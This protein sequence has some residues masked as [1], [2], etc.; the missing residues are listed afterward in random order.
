[1]AVAQARFQLPRPGPLYVCAQFAPERA[2]PSPLERYVG[3][4]KVAR[5]RPTQGAI[6]TVV[7][8][9]PTAR[10]PNRLRSGSR[11]TSK[12]PGTSRAGTNRMSSALTSVCAPHAAPTNAALTKV[13]F[14][15]RRI[16][17]S[18]IRAMKSI[19]GV[20]DIKMPL[21]IQKLG[22]KAANAAA[23]NPT[24]G[25]A[26]AFP[27]SPTQRTTPAPRTAMVRSCPVPVSWG[28]TKPTAPRRNVVKGG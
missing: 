17:A 22:A 4:L 15:K 23:T 20:S 5:F 28:T 27:R 14:R 3:S 7:A 11:G 2:S 25:P 12:T 9:N 19:D 1:M 16:R 8:T 18:R 21:G 6:T 26:T 24:R 10:R 13:G